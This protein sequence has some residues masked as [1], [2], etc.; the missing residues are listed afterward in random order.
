MIP[1]LATLVLAV[2]ASAASAEPMEDR[3]FL[4]VQAARAEGE[5]TP[6]ERRAELDAIA[7]RRAQE[8]AALPESER[9][10]VEVPVETLLAEAG[11][12]RFHRART[13]VDLQTGSRD[14]AASA[15]GR[16]QGYGVSW[17]DAMDPRMDAIGLGSAASEDGWIVLVAILLEDQRIP[18]D[19]GLVED[20]VLE[21][22]N[23]TREGRGLPALERSELIAQ[24]ARAHSRDMA[25]RG[26]FAHLSPGGIS[27]T[28][29]ARSRGLVFRRMAENIA[30]NQRADD[31]ARTAVDGWMASSAHRENLLD[32]EMTRTGVGVAVDPDGMVYITQVFLLPLASD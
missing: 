9:L 3:V 31:P 16:W 26:Y 27:A 19:V 24:L 12:H 28:A 17:S 6:L 23:R 13:Y 11:I 1:I 30:R 32:P 4:R 8:M 25:S 18:A 20:A 29:R 21:L 15:I 5:A 22:V 10:Q 2:L 14:P 7:S